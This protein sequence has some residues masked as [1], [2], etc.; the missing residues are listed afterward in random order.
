LEVHWSS[1]R[2]DQWRK[3]QADR[4]W[5]LTEGHAPRPMGTEKQ[6]ASAAR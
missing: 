6:T 5:L 4:Y 2:V 1:G 3:L